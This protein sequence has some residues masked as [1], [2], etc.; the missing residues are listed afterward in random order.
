MSSLKRIVP[1]FGRF[2][3][4]GLSGT[5]V[6]LV[7]LWFLVN[8]G[9]D[10]FLAALLAT[11]FSIINN[12]FWNDQWTFKQESGRHHSILV[13]FL[14]FQAVA[15]ITAVMTLGLFSL[16]YQGLQIHYLLAQFCAIGSATLVNF[17]IN[18]WLTWGL[19]APARVALA[20]IS[21]PITNVKIVKEI[22]EC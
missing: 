4:V 19:F 13:R 20:S 21:G 17:S 18:G 9:M 14:R 5:I 1:T 12:F 2:L 15:S 6:N 3:A 16:F 10:H 8:L 11:E 7:L 22:E